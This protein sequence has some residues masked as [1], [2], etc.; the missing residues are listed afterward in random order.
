M[1]VHSGFPKLE[2]LQAEL[3][4]T[5]KT[6]AKESLQL[7][8]CCVSAERMGEAHTPGHHFGANSSTTKVTPERFNGAAFWD[9]RGRSRTASSPANTADLPGARHQHLG[10]RLGSGK[11]PWPF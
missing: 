4:I 10:L 3:H 11:L 9:N 1:L 2:A 8:W 5:S 6:S 7:A